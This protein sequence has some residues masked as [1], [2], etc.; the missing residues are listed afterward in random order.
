MKMAKTR[1]TFNQVRGYQRAIS[2]E[3]IELGYNC[4]SRRE[5]T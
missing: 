1:E 5:P 3:G 2:D 4:Q